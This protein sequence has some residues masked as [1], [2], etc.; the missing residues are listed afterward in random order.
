[1]SIPAVRQ[2][3]ILTR[4]PRFARHRCEIRAVGLSEYRAP[5]RYRLD[6][7]DR[8][9]ACV[10][11]YTLEGEGRFDDGHTV[12]PVPKGTAFFVDTPSETSYRLPRH[13]NAYWRFLWV[14]FA[15]ET[16]LYHGRRLI[17]QHGYLMSLPDSAAPLQT[18]RKF[19]GALVDGESIDDLMINLAGHR[20]LLELDRAL[21]EPAATLPDA[22]RTAQALIDA[23]YAEADLEIDDLA[24]AA[25]YSKYY[26]CRLFRES[27]GGSPYQALLA[28]RMQ[29]AMELLTETSMPIKEIAVKVGFNDVSWFS[30][31]FKRLMHTTPASVRRRRRDLGV[32][33]E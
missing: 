2:E 28:R 30:S 27:T 3:F 5:D 24:Q 4:L 26:F 32:A 19:H 18:L 1:M 21:S 8:G 9:E 6:N 25:G 14:V 7:R 17:R 22:V 20:L 13:S 12:R 11:Q 10:F 29:A 16:G 31:T 15:G 23:R 33:P